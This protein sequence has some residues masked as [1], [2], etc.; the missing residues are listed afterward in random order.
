MDG[1][2]CLWD[3]NRSSCVEI[4]SHFGSITK[5]IADANTNV[6]FSAG[7]DGKIYSYSFGEASK[8]KGS[9]VLRSTHCFQGHKA[10][11]MDIEYFESTLCSGAR[12]G[13]VY[14]WDV[15]VGAVSKRYHG[16]K[17]SVTRVIALDA[18]TCVTAGID[19]CVK[20]FDAREKTCVVNVLVS[21]SADKGTAAVGCLAHIPQ[22]RGDH[23]LVI[24]GSADGSITVLDL[25]T[26][27]GI[28]QRWNHYKSPVYTV[29][30][31]G[32]ECFFSGG[33]DGMLLCYDLK[34]ASGLK[35][36]LCGSEN[37][38]VQCVFHMGEGSIAAV[39]ESG[40]L[41]MYKY[42]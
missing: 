17:D 4:R 39:G 23:G 6:G 42:Q 38:A 3:A 9:S 11:V 28:V 33:G 30:P 12:D 40:N 22:G 5:A 34:S 24:A 2:L 31:L 20:L 10:P 21:A 25:R 37:G 8:Q 15:G 14:F 7:Y 29:A 18:H 41:L 36:G 19:G 26:V 27:R 13:D 1:K 16:H 35:Y 32:A